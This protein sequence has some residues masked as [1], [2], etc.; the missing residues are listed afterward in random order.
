MTTFDAVLRVQLRHDPGRPLVTWYDHATGERVELSVTTYANWVAKAASL[1]VE[2]GDLERGMRLRVDLP[3]H[4]LSPVFLGAAWTVG[5]VLTSA[6]DPDAVVCG[7]DSLEGWAARADEVVVL[8]C[9]LLP[10]GVRFADPVPPGV[11]D[12][13]LEIWSQP[14]AFAPWDPPTGQDAATGAAYGDRSQAALME[15]A[16]AGSLLTDGGRLFS[17]ANPASP[18]GIATFTEPLV[19]GGSL[20]LVRHPD[21]AR[22]DATYAAE[23]ATHRAGEPGH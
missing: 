9:S 7:P 3:T 19:R 1:L 18:P 17:V 2:E 13:G 22:L 8:A 14:D 10:L 4:W 20:V 23:R 12:V 11:H 15:S 21:P 6:D 5:L 16:A